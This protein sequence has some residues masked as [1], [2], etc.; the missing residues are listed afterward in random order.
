MNDTLF[1]EFSLPVLLSSV[2]SIINFIVISYK[3]NV[4]MFMLTQFLMLYSNT[5]GWRL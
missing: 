5:L 1:I 4:F 3:V 2:N